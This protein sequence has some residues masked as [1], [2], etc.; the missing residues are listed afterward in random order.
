[1]NDYINQLLHL[2]AEPRTHHAVDDI[3]CRVVSIGWEECLPTLLAG[4]ESEDPNVRILVLELI[5]K[6]REYQS[7]VEALKPHVIS[8]LDDPDQLVRQQAIFT[9]D[10]L[11]W[12]EDVKPQLRQIVLR[13][14]SPIAAKALEVLIAFD[15][16]EFEKVRASLKSTWRQ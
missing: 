12:S 4:L 8:A 3:W 7:D 14:D 11:C 15:A 16:D 10:S 13:D 2:L 5:A 6:H 9:I 1:M